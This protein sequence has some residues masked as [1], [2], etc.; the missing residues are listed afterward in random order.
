MNLISPSKCAF[1][2]ARL[3]SIHTSATNSYQTAAIQQR[4]LLDEIFL[5]LTKEEKQIFENLFA[6]INYCERKYLFDKEVIDAIHG[7]RLRLN[8]LLFRSELKAT[9][10]DYLFVFSCLVTLIQNLSEA[11]ALPENLWLI[12]QEA[13]VKLPSWNTAIPHTTQ[14]ELRVGSFDNRK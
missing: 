3:S 8:K 10:K 9:R 2:Y 13:L 6:R 12:Q 11:T 5:D 7:A 1:Y 4:Q 14:V